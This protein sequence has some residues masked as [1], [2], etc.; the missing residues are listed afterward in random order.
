MRICQIVL[1]GVVLLLSGC[2]G[3]VASKYA[4]TRAEQSV[5]VLD[6]EEYEKMGYEYVTY[7]T[8]SAP[9]QLIATEGYSEYYK[10]SSGLVP[11]VEGGWRVIALMSDGRDVEGEAFLNYWVGENPMDSACNFKMVGIF[12]ERLTGREKILFSGR[13]GDKFYNLFGREVLYDI[14]KFNKSE[15]GE[16]QRY[17]FS[18]GGTSL[19]EYGIERMKVVRVGSSAWKQYVFAFKR[20][21]PHK[22]YVPRGR[23]KEARSTKLQNDRFREYA[24]VELGFDA[25]GRY[26]KKGALQI[27]AVGAALTGAPAMLVA[28]V[29]GDYAASAVDTRWTGHSA[30]AISERG[31]LA[32]AIKFSNN[33]C[34]QAGSGQLV[35]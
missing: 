34:R 6:P 23:Q 7:F 2:S 5:S 33:W 8:F 16:Y 12:P 32:Q 9:A 28:G 35:R 4:L 1:V 17:V 29:A 27:G 3:V 25:S 21:M 14:E 30:R 22:Y 15:E 10:T 26:L 19:L 31:A 13:D 18:K 24:T 20:I 11:I